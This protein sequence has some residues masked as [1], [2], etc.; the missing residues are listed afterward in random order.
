MT[1]SDVES[2]A[3]PP[4]VV[5]IG[6]AKAVDPAG[7]VGDVAHLAANGRSVVVVHGG[8]TVVDETL[9]RLGIEPEYVESASGVTGRFTDAETMEAFSMAMAGKLNTE[10]TAAFRSAGVD[11][12]G[13]SGVDGGLLSG[14][15]KS[16]VRVVEDGK[17]KI[18]RGDHSGKI[19]SVNA[20]LLADLLDGGY[21]PVVSPPMAGDEG[22][23]E[24]TPVNADADRAAAAVAGA[25]DA[26]LVLLT[27]V[28]GVYADPDDPETRIDSAATPDEL[29]AVEDAAEGFMGKKV[30]AARE[31][32]EGGSGRV[33]I[34]D[35]NVRDPVVA[36]LGGEGTTV[37]R[38]ALGDAD[39][40][41]GDADGDG[42]DD[43][44][45]A[46]TE[47]GETA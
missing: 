26:D 38:S 25:L 29:A 7:A 40:D 16:A 37:E 31:A 43:G 6:G 3:E 39:G 10:L 45:P 12:V 30:M 14:P 11:A 34:A 4:V 17:K 18:R 5:K 22:D 23:G 15:R 46:E 41:T 21:T 8:S 44:E 28:S 20:D 36:A 19:E 42:A 9:E 2:A 32:L 24:V 27:D 13:L 47:G 33:V 1:G 35:A